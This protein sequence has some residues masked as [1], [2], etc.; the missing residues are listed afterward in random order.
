M[1]WVHSLLCVLNTLWNVTPIAY[2]HYGNIY[3]FFADTTWT[4]TEVG[5]FSLMYYLMCWLLLAIIHVT[6]NSEIWQGKPLKTTCMF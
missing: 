2:K 3:V 5:P 1:F 4:E 6:I